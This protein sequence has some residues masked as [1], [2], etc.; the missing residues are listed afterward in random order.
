MYDG[1]DDENDIDDCNNHGSNDNDNVNK[2]NSN[3]HLHQ[4]KQHIYI[5]IISINHLNF[6]LPIIHQ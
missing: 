3:D 2:N 5:N 1:N 6:L 4:L